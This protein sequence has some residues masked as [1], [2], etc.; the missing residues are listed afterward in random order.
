M[1]LACPCDVRRAGV[2]RQDV[3]EGQEVRFAD[4]AIPAV[5]FQPTAYAGDADLL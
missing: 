1:R 4:L 3:A 5:G 2:R